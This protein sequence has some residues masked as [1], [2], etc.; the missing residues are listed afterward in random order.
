MLKLNLITGFIG[1]ALFSTVAT[2]AKDTTVNLT[3]CLV[4]GQRAH[5]YSVTDDSGKTFE[6]LPDRGVYMKKHLGQKV[7]VTG[8][9]TRQK[10]ATDNFE[11]LRVNQV[12]RVDA[13]CS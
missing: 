12:K 11:Y 6:L 2:Q 5:E 10:Q 9:V 13:S 8:S 3:G 1:F 4:Q 7:M